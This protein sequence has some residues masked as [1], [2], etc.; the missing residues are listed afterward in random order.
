MK[1]FIAN[2][3]RFGLVCEKN[4]NIFSEKGAEGGQ[5]PFKKFLKIHSFSR[6][7]ASL[8]DAARNV[9]TLF[10]C[11]VLSWAKQRAEASAPWAL[12]SASHQSHS[13]KVSTGAHT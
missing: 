11:L 4:R 5:G 3:V 8:T 13:A 1:I 2:L 7:V 9:A 10:L 12:G 6:A